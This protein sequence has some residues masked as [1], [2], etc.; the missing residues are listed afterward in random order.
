[1]FVS[2]N[3]F[4]FAFSV[5]IWY[6][7]RDGVMTTQG[8]NTFTGDSILGIKRKEK[9]HMSDSEVLQDISDDLRYLIKSTVP[10]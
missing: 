1:M 3:E 8:C 6:N 7:A 9:K 5:F 2:E 4:Q 10:N